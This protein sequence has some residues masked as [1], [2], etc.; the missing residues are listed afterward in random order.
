MKIWL[1]DPRSDKP[2]VSLTLLI[3][4]FWLACYKLF[5]NQI[6]GSD[7][8]MIVGAVSGL[9]SVRKYQKKD[10]EVTKDEDI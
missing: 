5:V 3:I 1:K 6:S 2:S 9:Y 4:G 7:F 8:A 10:E